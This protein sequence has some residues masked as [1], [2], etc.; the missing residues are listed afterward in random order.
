MLF[1]SEVMIAIDHSQELINLINSGVTVALKILR[2]CCNLP[3]NLAFII[4]NNGLFGV[5][6]GAHSHGANC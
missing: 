5:N 2:F 4:N 6:N 3:L 1:L